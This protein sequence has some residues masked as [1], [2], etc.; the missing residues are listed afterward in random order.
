MGR[1]CGS[2]TE[3]GMDLISKRF[4]VGDNGGGC[5]MFSQVLGWGTLVL[6][7]RPKASP[8][9]AFHLSPAG[10][11]SPASPSGC[12]RALG[13]EQTPAVVTVPQQHSADP[14]ACGAHLRP[15]QGGSSQ[16]CPC[17]WGCKAPHALTRYSRGQLQEGGERG[18]R[19]RRDKPWQ[20]VVAGIYPH[21]LR[22][23]PT[24][25]THSWV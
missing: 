13:H 18:G 2:K 22:S 10:T 6:K 5:C 17:I 23:P 1:V 16:P 19:G 3:R 15:G 24:F 21:K 9:W 7:A 12:C 20:M 4:G 14:R 25:T 8:K 11:P